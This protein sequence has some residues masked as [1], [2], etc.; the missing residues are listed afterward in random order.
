MSPLQALVAPFRALYAR[1]RLRLG[2]QLAVFAVLVGS[3]AYSARGSWHEAGS[4]VR[5]ADRVDLALA[6][7]AIAAYYLAF[8]IGWQVILRAMGVDLRYR[9]ALRA[10]MLSMVAKYVP[11]GVWTPAARVV[12]LRRVN[13]VDTPLVL[14][15]IALEAGLSA[16]AGVLVF[17]AALP[18]VE[19][20]D[21]PVWWLAGLAALL[22]VL[23]HPRVFRPAAGRIARLLGGG[24]VPAVSQRLMLTLVAYYSATWLLAGTGL[25]FLAASVGDPHPSAIPYLG[26]VSAVGA[27]VTVL[28]VIAPSGLGAREGAMYGLLI[29]VLS[30]PA[31]LGTVVLNRFAITVVEVALLGIVGTRTRAD[32]LPPD[33]ADPAAAADASVAF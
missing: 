23:L 7:L 32:E 30:P 1:P 25:Y 29:A 14:G 28:V 21:P 10:E 27:I 9:T 15:S 18:T 13:V 26:G 11:G 19:A 16:I 31:A 22:A 24:E 33:E 3:L 5:S 20:N 8:V 2:I 17:T 6:L 4:L 12:A